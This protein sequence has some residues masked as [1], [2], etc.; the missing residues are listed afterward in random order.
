V[1]STIVVVMSDDLTHQSLI[2][3]DLRHEF[4]CT[5]KKDS[6]YVANVT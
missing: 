5:L 2:S 4:H 1:I 3:V 6:F